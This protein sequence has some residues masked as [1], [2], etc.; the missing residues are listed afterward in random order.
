MSYLPCLLRS[1]CTENQELQSLQRWI[2]TRKA[3]GNRFEDVL[4]PASIESSAMT[5]IMN[6]RSFI[7]SSILESDGS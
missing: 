3:S 7:S 5:A 6:E 1:H 2:L 4:F